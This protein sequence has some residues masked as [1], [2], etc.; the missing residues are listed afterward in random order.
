MSECWECSV[1]WPGSIGYG[2]CFEPQFVDCD[3]EIV[4]FQAFYLLHNRTCEMCN[5]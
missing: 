1:W 4:D 5:G 2:V 3:V